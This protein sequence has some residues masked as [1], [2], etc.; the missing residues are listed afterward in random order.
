MAARLPAK[1]AEDRQ[2]RGKK[3]W[4]D[5]RDE[6]RGGSKQSPD[7]ARGLSAATQGKSEDG[8][9][10]AGR[11]AGLPEDSGN[12]EERQR[13]SPEGSGEQGGALVEQ[14]ASEMHHQPDSQ[15]A[16]ENVQQNEDDRRGKRKAAE[17]QKDG[18]DNGGV[19][20]SDDRRRT[21]CAAEGRAVAQTVE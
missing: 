9:K 21:G 6:G 20:R 14:G 5:E 13:E 18:R 10:R 8:R 11:E 1:P 16:E 7:C 2:K 12:P 4:I 17:D 15:Q 3:R 19:A